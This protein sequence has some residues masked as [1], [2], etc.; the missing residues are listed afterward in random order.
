MH[1]P[2]I[3]QVPAGEQDLLIQVQVQLQAQDQLKQV[4]LQLQVAGHRSRI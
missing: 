2:V 3:L 4:R 1:Q